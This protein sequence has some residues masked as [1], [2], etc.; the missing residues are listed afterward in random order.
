MRRCHT[1]DQWGCSSNP[2]DRSCQQ[3][4]QSRGNLHNR[5]GT[6]LKDYPLREVSLF[7]KSEVTL[8]VDLSCVVVVWGLWS[9]PRARGLEPHDYD[10]GRNQWRAYIDKSCSPYH[11]FA[12]IL[13]NIGVALKMGLE[14]SNCCVYMYHSASGGLHWKPQDDMTKTCILQPPSTIPLI[15]IFNCLEKTEFNR[16]SSTDE[17]HPCSPEVDYSAL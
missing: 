7:S 14:K 12:F 8:W 17:N 6:G 2:V 15:A 16:C 10:D 4:W 13:F 5:E 1:L 9:S 3:V 11:K